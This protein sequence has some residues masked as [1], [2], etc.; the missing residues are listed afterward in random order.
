LN[1]TV[2]RESWRLHP[3]SWIHRAEARSIG[4]ELRRAGYAVRFERYRSDS[5]SSLPS[6]PL[7][8][9]VSDPVM[10]AAVKAFTRVATPYLGPSP[11]VIERC[12]DK[13]QAYHIATANGVDCPA[14]T[15]AAEADT[16]PFPLVLK[17]RRGSDSIGV[18]IL[19]AGPIPASLRTDGY[20]AQPYVRGA[21]LTVAVLHER[22]GTPLRIFLPEETPY[23]FFRKYLLRPQRAPL[24]DAGLAERVRRSAL[25]IARIFG[26]DW[27][28]RIDLIHETATDRLCFLECDVVPLIG[29]HSAFAASLEAGGIRRAE[30]LRLLL[31]NIADK[32]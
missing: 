8:L 16:I 15:L 1:V 28:A 19:R 27:A 31:M 18:R 24:A 14:T 21:E 22:A 25:K 7:L 9:G 4:E 26:V 12:Y 20:I 29:A 23:S 2:L 13:Y 10:L 32:P 30:Q 3:L 5:V 6:G 17:P 11:A